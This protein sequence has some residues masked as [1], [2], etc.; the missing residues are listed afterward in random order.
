MRWCLI[1]SGYKA[2]VAGVARKSITSSLC[3]HV[4]VARLVPT[5]RRYGRCTRSSLQCPFRPHDAVCRIPTRVDAKA[6]TRP[7]LQQDWNFVAHSASAA[8]HNFAPDR[9]GASRGI[10]ASSP[11][12][13]RASLIAPAPGYRGS[14]RRREVAAVASGAGVHADTPRPS[15]TVDWGPAK[16]DGTGCRRRGKVDSIS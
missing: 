5:A 8:L 3:N 2:K 4:W 14:R 12:D 1:Q 9:P 7:C 15:S 6:V 11:G 10:D 13:E 16:G